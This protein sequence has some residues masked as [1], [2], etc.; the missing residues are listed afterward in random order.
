M[1]QYLFSFIGVVA[2]M[3]AIY[4]LEQLKNDV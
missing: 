3:A 4:L 2:I 1:I